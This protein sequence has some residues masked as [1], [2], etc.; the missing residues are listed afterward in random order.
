[1][2]L[3]DQGAA[4]LMRQSELTPQALSESL[5]SLLS[6]PEKLAEMGLKARSLAKPEAAQ[7]VADI[8]LEVAL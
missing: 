1:M 3:V 2:Y 4:V 7:L 5:K 8:C 6:Q